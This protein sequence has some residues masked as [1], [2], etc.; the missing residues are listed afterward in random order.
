MTATAKT[1]PSDA[2]N[3]CRMVVCM[4]VPDRLRQVGAPGV[5]I[6]AVVFCEGGHMPDVERI[7]VDEAHK[8]VAGQQALLVCAY[9]EEAKCR[10]INLDGSIS[11]KDFQSRLDSVPKTQEIIFYCA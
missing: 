11:L 5:T 6:L 9:E 10:M 2:A 4:V 3:G 8:K 7:S 1:A